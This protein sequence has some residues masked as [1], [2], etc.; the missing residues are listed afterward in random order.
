[1]NF[2]DFYISQGS[3]QTRINNNFHLVA[4]NSLLPCQRICTTHAGCCAMVDKTTRRMLSHAHC[5]SARC[6]TASVVRP[7]VA[8][9]G[10][11]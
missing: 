10:R 5:H 8:A 11:R 9:N 6:I 3:Q 7:F 2:F 1:M 4:L